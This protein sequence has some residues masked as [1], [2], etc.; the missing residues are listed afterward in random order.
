M[1]VLERLAEVVADLLREDPRRVLTGEDVRDGGMLGLSRGASEDEQLQARLLATPLS[2][3]VAIAHAA[4]LALAG[5]RPILL[6]PSAGALLDG[7]S[8]LREAAQVRWRSGDQRSVPLLIVAP[9]GPGFSLGGEGALSPEATLAQVPGLRVVAGGRAEELGALVRAAA[10]FE[11]GLDPTVLLLPRSLLLT[12]ADA[13]D[14]ELDRPIS[15]SRRLTHGD[16]VTVFTWGACVDLAVRA[17]EHAQVGV[18]VVD[19]TSLAPLDTDALVEAARETGKLVIAHAGPRSHGIGAELAAMFA[20][21]AILHLDA[22][23]MR[24]CG[25]REPASPASEPSALPSVDAITDAILHV[26]NY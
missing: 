3:S 7:L 18:T 22:P 20:D 26:A 11:A 2:P 17:A 24:V 8:A 16:A 6:L 25:N 4:G 15:A 9:S 12:D 13:L 23:I 10:A 14:T 21:Q 1:S 5:A 19:L